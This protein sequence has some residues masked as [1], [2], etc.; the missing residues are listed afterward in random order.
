MWIGYTI[1][2]FRFSICNPVIQSFL[3]LH[4]SKSVTN[5]RWGIRNGIVAP[6]SCTDAP[7]NNDAMHF[8]QMIAHPIYV[9][10]PTTVIYHQYDCVTNIIMAQHF[11]VCNYP[12]RHGTVIGPTSE[13]TFKLSTQ[14]VKATKTTC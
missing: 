1:R 10:V 7:L 14:S 9:I 13:A 8:Y 6:R 2:I 11:T 4:P 3:F 12:G 5:Y